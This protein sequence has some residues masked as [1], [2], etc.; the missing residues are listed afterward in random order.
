MDLR[1]ASA[2]NERYSRLH[3]L[4]TAW[5]E[6]IESA[7]RPYRPERHYMRGP[8]P[9][10][11]ARHGMSYQ[12]HLVLAAGRRLAVAAGHEVR[13]RCEAL[14]SHEPIRRFATGV[15]PCW[16]DDA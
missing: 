7:R 6:L 14:E 3:E 15:S 9:A 11:H 10:W 2:L 4:V 12:G 8:G 13:D 5:H 16:L 1:F